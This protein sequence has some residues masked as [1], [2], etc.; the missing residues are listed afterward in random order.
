[1]QHFIAQFLA[2]ED[3]G[4]LHREEGIATRVVRMDV[5]VDQNSNGRGAE[6]SDRL[7][8]FFVQLCVLGV[9]R[10]DAVRAEEHSDPAAGRVRVVRVKSSARGS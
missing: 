10:Q 7:Q 9:D 2:R 8:N 1:V 6:R 5:R 3:Q 4:A